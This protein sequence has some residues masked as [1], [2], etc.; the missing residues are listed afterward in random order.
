MSAARSGDESQD[1]VAAEVTTRGHRGHGI[2]EISVGRRAVLRGALTGGAAVATLGLPIPRSAHAED[3]VPRRGGNLR[4]A[5]LGGSS[6]DSLDPHSCVVQ[7]DTARTV[8]LYDPLVEMNQDATLVNALAES[9]E[10]NPTATEWTIRL[11]KGVTFHDGKPLTA[12]DVAYT[13]RRILDPRAP[14]TGALALQPLDIDNITLLDTRTLRIPTKVPYANL[15][16]C[17]S[18]SIYYGIVPVDF[19]PKRPVG[20]GA[21][22]YE[23]FTPGQQSV[24]SRFDDHWRPGLPY[25]D[26]L[27]IIDS[28]ASEVAAFNALQGGQVD[29]LASAPLTLVRQ[30]AAGGPLKALVSE[31]GQWTPF[32]MR[33]DQ[34]PFD[35]PNVRKA[36]R[37]LVDREQ[38]IKVGLNGLGIA[39]ADVFAPWDPLFDTSLRRERDVDQAKFLLRKAGEDRLEVELVTSD[40]ANRVPQLAQIF[41]VQAADA[42]VKVRVRQVPADVFYGDQYL[43]WN[44]AQ[45]YWYYTPYLPQ[46]S[47]CSLPGATYNE[48]HWTDERY[49][50]LF[51]EARGTVDLD[52][53]RELAWELQ[54]IDFEEGGLIIPSF[55]RGV[56]LLANNVQGLQAGRTGRP[57]GNYAFRDIWLS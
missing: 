45:D 42:G 44:F 57:L 30:L 51:H 33:V 41:A 13:F 48:T 36:F 54:K 56:D 7:A 37:L 8:A 2:D 16:E 10:P 26:R 14:L 38:M 32:T 35:D 31:P 4:V 46:I 6:A 40:I 11:R 19:D 23:S 27:T 1:A 43:Q 18:S 9:I 28:F 5:M 20:T 15:P 24:F 47:V 17:V 3:A 22:K 25:L 55:N 39:A 52:K 21:F 34:P 49:A 50:K 12:A 29:A 53:R